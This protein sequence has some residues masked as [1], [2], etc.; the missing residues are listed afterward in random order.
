[1]NAMQL[2]LS[3]AKL[4]SKNQMGQFENIKTL[5]RKIKNGK[6]SGRNFKASGFEANV[7][8]STRHSW[9]LLRLLDEFRTVLFEY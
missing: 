9:K 3:L 4:D 2:K 6:H 8:R 7:M 1:M 5:V